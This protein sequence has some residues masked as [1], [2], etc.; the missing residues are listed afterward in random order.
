M[1]K[2]LM[3]LLLCAIMVL[4]I[5]LT[6]CSDKAG[7]GDET[8]SS[9]TSSS[10]KAMTITLYTITESSTTDEALAQVEEAINVITESDFNTHVILRTATEKQY[11]K[12]IDDAIEAK[13]EEIRIAEEEAAA[14]KAAEKA[15]RE[16]AKKAAKENGGK[17]VTT[18][19]ET[20]AETTISEDETVLNEYGLEET[21]YPEEDGTQ[22]DIFLINSFDMFT[23]YQS[24]GYLAQL[25]EQLSIGSKIL[26]QYIHPNFLSAAKVGG[27][28]YAIPNNHTFGEYEYLL[29]NK[30]VF[31]GLYY[32]I[33]NV[34]TFNDLEEYFYDILKYEKGVTPLLGEYDGNVY[35]FDKDNSIYGSVIPT[36]LS[37]PTAAPPTNLITDPAF[38]AYFQ[39]MKTLREANGISK[40]GK[41]GDGKTYG[42]VVMK[43]DYNTPA[44]YEEDYYVLTLKAPTA[45]NE[46]VYTGM[47]AVSKFAKDVARCMDII[48]Y[49]S[50]NK[51]FINLFTYGIEDVHY[52]KD[53]VT[54]VI[55]KIGKDYAMNMAYT[56]NQFMMYQSTDMSAE[57]KALSDD[58]WALAK[59]Q[60]L[61]MVKHP[62]LGFVLQEQKVDP[63]DKEK[64]KMVD[65]MIEDLASGEKYSI[66]DALNQVHEMSP[67][68]LK[69]LEE[70]KPYTEIQELKRRVRNEEGQIVQI[71]EEVEVEITFI[72][73]LNNLRIELAENKPLLALTFSE[74]TETPFAQYNKWFSTANK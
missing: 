62:Y 53:E 69:D 7:S 61:D 12:M 68:I 22:L 50:T 51:D 32:D 59:L 66:R 8:T 36:D 10:S 49:L 70:F 45:T 4:P 17:A 64:K 39:I 11:E 74:A 28:T 71:T 2:R 44:E 35:Y 37:T 23:K 19:A 41:I 47:Y 33:D 9:T 20:T 5:A 34:K 52:T 16:A 31:D 57:M 58:N 18:A 56:G 38:M 3:S 46:N 43:G 6:G 42:A 60:N 21:V 72:D 27:K 73:F 40:D 1:K 26:K 67:K 55:T 29:I 24:A 48:T 14:K 54:D 25:D 63:E 13:E 65:I 15:A 30:K